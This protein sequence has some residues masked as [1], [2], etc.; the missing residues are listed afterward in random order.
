MAF[1]CKLNYM[2]STRKGYTYSIDP[3]DCFMLIH[4]LM[5]QNIYM[6]M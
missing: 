4:S 6:Y 5:Q 1:D 3:T 2:Q